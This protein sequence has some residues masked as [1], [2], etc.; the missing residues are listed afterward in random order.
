MNISVDGRY[1]IEMLIAAGW[2]NKA[3]TVWLVEGLLM[4][5][6]QKSSEH[7]LQDMAGQ[8]DFYLGALKLCRHI[9]SDSMCTVLVHSSTHHL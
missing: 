9:P 3:P 6:T 2:S 7:L 8:S 5:L 1:W 4:Y